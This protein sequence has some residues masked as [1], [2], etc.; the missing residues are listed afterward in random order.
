[1]TKRQAYWQDLRYIHGVTGVWVRRTSFAAAHEL[2]TAIR[3]YTAEGYPEP[4]ATERS[5]DHLKYNR[6][7]TLVLRGAAI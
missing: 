5:Y 2:A 7:G 3:Y 6:K 1:M 4:L